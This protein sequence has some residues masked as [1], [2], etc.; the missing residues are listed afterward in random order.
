MR[1]WLIPHGL[2]SACLANGVKIVNLVPVDCSRVP[3][4]LSM[5]AESGG[6]CIVLQLRNLWETSAAHEQLATLRWPARSP[7]FMH[8][9]SA[10]EETIGCDTAVYYIAVVGKEFVEW[11]LEP[12]VR[13]EQHTDRKMTVDEPGTVAKL[14]GRAKEAIAAEWPTTM[15]M[16]AARKAI[17]RTAPLA[18]DALVRGKIVKQDTAK[19]LRGWIKS[20][21][22]S[23]AYGYLAGSLLT[24]HPKVAKRPWLA[25]LAKHMRLEGGARIVGSVVDPLLSA[26]EAVL[27]GAVEE[28]GIEVEESES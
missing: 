19:I 11:L 16:V 17:D 12:E 27:I 1:L 20:D 14:T 4:Y 26:V 3:P 15:W 2:R 8:V 21:V 24:M 7:G 5:L 9:I 23:G 18:I 25:E 10:T 13:M 28:T 22:G 6:T